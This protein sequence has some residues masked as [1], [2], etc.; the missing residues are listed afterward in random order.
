MT[1][2]HLSKTVRSLSLKAATFLFYFLLGVGISTCIYS[3]NIVASLNKTTEIRLIIFWSVVFKLF[4]DL[5]YTAEI[6]DYRV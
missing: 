1:L 2:S 5:S 4:E 6:A 3:S